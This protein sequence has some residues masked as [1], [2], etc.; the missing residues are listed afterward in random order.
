VVVSVIWINHPEIA[1]VIT[2]MSGLLA[3][4]NNPKT[5]QLILSGQVEDVL[6][7]TDIQ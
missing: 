5:V 3:D 1:N 2:V 7:T 6:V 4:A